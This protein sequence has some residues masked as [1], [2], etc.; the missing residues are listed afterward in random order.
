M[1]CTV[2][3]K[4]IITV[5]LILLSIQ[6]R[7]QNDIN[8]SVNITPPYSPRFTE[9]VE[10][11]G[12]IVLIIQNK[13]NQQK[14]IYLQGSIKGDNGVSLYSDPNV[15]PATPLVLNPN[16]VYFANANNLE[17]LFAV[18]KYKMVNITLTE[19][20]TKNGLPEGNYDVCV[21]AYDYNTGQALSG[22]APLGCKLLP[23]A[24]L[25]PPY[26]IKPALDEKVKSMEPQTQVFSWTIPAGAEPGT[27]YKLRI[28]E[29]L[30]SKKNIN[31]AYNS[32]T[33]PTFFE[34]IV[35]ANV[36]VYGPG[37]PKLV[38]G[39]KY[40]WAV[41]AI[42]GPK[43]IA[44]KNNGRSEVRSFT[45]GEPEPPKPTISLLYPAD[46]AEMPPIAGIGKNIFTFKWSYNFPNPKG[47]LYENIEMYEV[48]PGQT[49]EQAVTKNENCI[50]TK[51]PSGSQSFNYNCK[52]TPDGKTF[53]WFVVLNDNSGTPYKSEI[54]TFTVGSNTNDSLTFSEFDLCGFKVKVNSLKPKGGY[55]YSGTG[56]TKLGKNGKEF[57]INF[58]G[59]TIQPFARG[60]D[61]SGKKEIFKD[62]RC[63]GYNYQYPVEFKFYWTTHIDYD[64]PSNT[65]GTL[66]FDAKKIT[67]T[68]AIMSEYDAGLKIFKVKE[69]MSANKAMLN[70]NFVWESPMIHYLKGNDQEMLT[71]DG[72]ST[73]EFNYET[74]FN[75]QEVFYLSHK[76]P[77]K[78]ANNKNLWLYKDGKIL[79]DLNPQLYIV[80]N[81]KNAKFDFYGTYTIT[82]PKKDKPDLAIPIKGDRLIYKQA[83]NKYTISLNDD[84]SAKA[85]FDTVAV[86]L[87]N[88]AYR[89]QI[90]NLKLSIA[91]NGSS[92]PFS[93]KKA[94]FSSTDGIYCKDSSVSDNEIQIS[95]FPVKIEKSK[96]SLVKSQL[97]Q[98]YVQGYITVPFIKQ[99]AGV[100]L[101]ILKE[102]VQEA[103]VDC[104]YEKEVVL[105]QNMNGDKCTLKPGTGELKSDRIEIGGDLAITNINNPNKGIDVKNISMPKFY[106]KPNGSVGIVNSSWSGG[107]V[108]FQKS[109]SYKGFK[110]T[111][112]NINLKDLAGKDKYRITLGGMVV[113]ADNLSSDSKLPNFSTYAD[114]DMSKN[115]GGGPPPNQEVSF[116]SDEVTGGRTDAVVDFGMKFKYYD[117]D[118]TFGIG[119]SAEGEFGM[120][121]PNDIKVHAKMLIAKAPEGFNYWFFE[122]GQENAMQIPTGLLDLGIYGFTGRVYYKMSHS[123]TN[124]YKDDYI[125]DG[126]K[127]IGV[128]GLTQLKTLS[129]N[130][131]KFWGKVAFE[132][133]TGSNWLESIKFRGDGDFVSD[134]VGTTGKVRAHDCVLDFYWEPKAIHGEF[135]LTADFYSAITAEAYA[136]FDVSGDAFSLWAG[137]TGYLFGNS[138]CSAADFGFQCTDKF[139][140]VW[141][142]YNLLDIDKSYDFGI[143]E[144]SILL[145]SWV[146][147]DAYINYSPFQFKGQG[148]MVGKLK[149]AGCRLHT[150]FG[151]KLNAQLMFPKPTCV[152]AGIEVET[153]LKDF[154][155]S[156]GIK[157]G[158]IFFGSCF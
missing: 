52:G 17:N 151:V 7:A 107:S 110:F 10:T 84:N 78:T 114:F 1:K 154:T 75:P 137:G 96:L 33:V 115:T 59:V 48:K 34:T 14:S 4:R 94:F 149:V 6:S 2:F 82:S 38:P 92:F 66:W 53:A 142:N 136:G 113:L 129:D 5:L 30:D 99:K 157:N 100:S 43:K 133:V 148:I 81:G 150:S 127:F 51:E 77:N 79:L 146:Y 63:V 49:P 101:N 44:Y 123:G 116:G 45:Y 112:Y 16:Q 19:L 12:K 65:G 90:P 130:G 122:A 69:V 120:K 60:T 8:L 83:I 64:V 62:W 54:R 29:M 147:A 57:S 95:G 156:A 105:F 124:I 126:S 89:A 18:E 119:F 20:V 21:R 11:P 140:N 23:I 73:A 31:D 104:D 76:E 22:D 13:T 39:R 91:Y 56:T 72:N 27:Q 15:K 28:V 74:G 98:L 109:G 106:I 141:G 118:P 36:F 155:V 103:Y 26:P 40:A 134:G 50:S 145:K 117:N 80:N 88:S 85:S 111:P 68:P 47:A 3:I 128:Y 24:N 61:P 143:C 55:V 93:Y 131:V 42:P 71:F 97:L 9:Y 35:P 139:V 138:S 102:G 153:P 152:S 144:P 125:P 67:F 86:D 58:W 108:P 41:T 25:E 135:N 132:V 32:A 121:Q 46:K 158:S 87:V 37:Q 70:G